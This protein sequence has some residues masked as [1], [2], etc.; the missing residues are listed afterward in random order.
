MTTTTCP[1]CGRPPRGISPVEQV[2]T[3]LVGPDVAPLLCEV[4]TMVAALA[5]GMDGRE[6]RQQNLV[7]AVMDLTG[8]AERTVVNTI[9]AGVRAGYLDREYRMDGDPPR[10]RSYLTWKETS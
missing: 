2:V 9:A 3:G 1:T 6:V 10:R 8:A 5:R 4:W 7:A